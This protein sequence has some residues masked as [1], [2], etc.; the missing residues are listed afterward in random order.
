M[1][2]FEHKE[3]NG[4]PCLHQRSKKD[5]GKSNVKAWREKLRDHE[6]GE[7]ISHR[8]PANDKSPT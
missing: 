1:D 7:E 6:N 2:G 8:K 4:F 3:L 5:V